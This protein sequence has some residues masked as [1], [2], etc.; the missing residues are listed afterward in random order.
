MLDALEKE[1]HNQNR[2]LSNMVATLLIEQVR[3]NCEPYL[4]TQRGTPRG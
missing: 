2:S 3:E 4:T 1:A